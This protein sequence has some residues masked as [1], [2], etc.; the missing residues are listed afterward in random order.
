MATPYTWHPGATC[1][2]GYWPLTPPLLADE[3]FSSWLVR[4]ALRHGCSPRTLADVVWPHARV[5]LQDVD[6]GF[7]EHRFRPLAK[8]SGVPI[9]ALMLSTL[10]PVIHALLGG[11]HTPPK[12]VWPWVLVL[13]SRGRSH[14][15][16]L[17]FCPECMRQPEPYYR[18]QQR[19]AWHCAC[20]IH[21]LQLVDHCPLCSAAVQPAL[22]KP[23][24]R[25]YQCH[26]CGQ[27]LGLTPS[28]AAV[29]PVL[30]FQQAINA[31]K[32]GLINY[33]SHPLSLSD[34]M[35]IIR[36]MVSFLRTAALR[37]STNT[38][39]FCSQMGIDL[40][41]VQPGPLGL[42]LEYLGPSARAGLLTNA[43]EIMRAGPDLFIEMAAQ[44]SLSSSCL[45]IPATGAPPLLN[46]MAAVLISHSPKTG[47][48]TARKPTHSPQQV[49]RTWARLQRR[50]R[51]HDLT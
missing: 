40:A 20:E 2:G 50:M 13:G 31:A 46:Q 17:Q 8:A 44:A 16:G 32:G 49:L 7:D 36:V 25:V 14:A 9:Q 5:W 23:G 15:G 27:N 22:L 3:L 33:G 41:S 28:R 45:L 10:R 37:P 51:R 38:T 4:A 19:L 30:E 34:W 42:P 35:I 12:G 29:G 21:G 43:W 11:V 48:R 6:R 39:R 1:L 18:I 26:H 24:K 47:A